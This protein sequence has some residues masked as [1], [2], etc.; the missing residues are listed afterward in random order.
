VE[1]GGAGASGG[2]WNGG[3]H[4][5]S[6]GAALLSRLLS[7][8]AI[9]LSTGNLWEVLYTLLYAFGKGMVG[10][11][12]GERVAR[13]VSLLLGAHA[14]CCLLLNGLGVA[15]LKILL[16]HYYLGCVCFD[17]CDADVT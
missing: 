16:L 7:L 2:R 11:G 8:V 1:R 14:M 15:E 3:A 17:A 13:I 5:E 6:L 4:V 9:A 10:P 12:F